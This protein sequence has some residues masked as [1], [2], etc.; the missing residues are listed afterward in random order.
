MFWLDITSSQP[1]MQL[2]LI[3]PFPMVLLVGL[4]W[5]RWWAIKLRRLMMEA[6]KLGESY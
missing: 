1:A 5:V 3:I 4:Y 6:L 2:N